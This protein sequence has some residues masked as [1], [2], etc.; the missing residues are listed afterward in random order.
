MLLLLYH[1]ICHITGINAWE[2]RR[3]TNIEYIMCSY[4]FAMLLADCIVFYLT[5]VLFI[6]PLETLAKLMKSNTVD[7]TY[8]KSLPG[9]VREIAPI[10]ILF[11][12]NS[13][14]AILLHKHNGLL[15]LYQQKRYNCTSIGLACTCSHY[16]LVIIDEVQYSDT[17]CTNML[18]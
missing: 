8:L 4:F 18:Y 12:F 14:F 16:E 1:S 9:Y 11:M 17:M 7:L 2:H 3:D 13:Q 6:K 10:H 15:Y 5:L